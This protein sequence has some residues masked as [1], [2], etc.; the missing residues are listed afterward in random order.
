M[1]TDYLTNYTVDEI[2]EYLKQ[3]DV[4]ERARPKIHRTRIDSSDLD[5]VYSL[6]D[7]WVQTIYNYDDSWHGDHTDVMRTVFTK[8][9]HIMYGEDV[10]R[11]WAT[12]RPEGCFL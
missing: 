5:D 8:L 2:K 11:R 6:I 9:L 4:W 10:V 7:D 3:R 1:A 12:S